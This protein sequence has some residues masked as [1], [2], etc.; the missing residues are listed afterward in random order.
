MKAQTI[1]DGSSAAHLLRV[2]DYL[3][4]PPQFLAV[5]E[6]RSSL[7]QALEDAGQH[8]IVLTNNGQPQAA[9][10]PFEALEAMRSAL[11]QLLV[12][13]MKVSF[14]RV[15]QEL[16]APPVNGQRA[17]PTSEA[18]LESLV[19]QARRKHAKADA[20]KHRKRRR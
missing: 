16:I 11:L 5:A 18:G 10:V 7:R 9:I 13:G 4:R 12:G 6:A 8:S 15:Q 17:E 1:S 14:E 20:G 2:A 3:S 19:R